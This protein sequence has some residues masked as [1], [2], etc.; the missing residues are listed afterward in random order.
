M[1]CSLLQ[2]CDGTIPMFLLFTISTVVMKMKE[3]RPRKKG[4]LARKLRLLL[5]LR[6]IEGPLSVQE[7]IIHVG[8]PENNYYNHRKE[9][10][11][12]WLE[13]ERKKAEVLMELQKRRFVC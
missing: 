10:E 11:S 9:I 8:I 6:G 3:I 12:A 13:A 2:S 4:Y 7:E 1:T 5:K